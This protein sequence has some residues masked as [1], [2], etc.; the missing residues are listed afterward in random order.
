M[1]ASKSI[2]YRR[3]SLFGLSK[4]DFTDISDLKLD[5]HIE[6]ITEDFPYCRESLIKQFLIEKGIIVQ[7]MR[8]RDSLHRVNGDGVNARKKGRL[9][10]QVYDVQGPNHFWHIDTNH[11]L[12]RWYFVVFGA[13][14]GFSRLPVALECRSNKKAKTVLECFLKG[15][16]NYSLPSRVRSHEGGEKSVSS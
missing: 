6:N 7:R 13:I 16:E 8:I 1:S 5:Q 9:H 15:V 3:I 11:M 14:D 10:R 2:I 4:S 12:V